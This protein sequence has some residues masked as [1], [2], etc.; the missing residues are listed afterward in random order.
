MSMHKIKRKTASNIFLSKF[1]KPSYSLL[2][3]PAL[4]TLTPTYRVSVC[5]YRI[6]VRVSYL[7]NNCL[8]KKDLEL[9]S[10]FKTAV[11]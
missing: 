10:S 9:T 8:V 3:S 11:N 7:W 1:E 5:K 6:S 4:T 2:H